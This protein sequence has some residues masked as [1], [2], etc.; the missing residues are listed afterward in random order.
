MRDLLTKELTRTPDDSRVA[1][2]YDGAL[3]NKKN[4][5]F[6]GSEH[7]GKRAAAIQTLLGTTKLNGI[8]PADWLRDTLDKLLVKE[9][10]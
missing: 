6:A 10:K 2:G 3:H 7:S 4:W 5:L 1:I 8:N 9:F